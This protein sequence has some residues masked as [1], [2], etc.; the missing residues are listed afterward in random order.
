[1]T[2]TV[3]VSEKMPFTPHCLDVIGVVRLLDR[4]NA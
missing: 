3:P 4:L 1:M 2:G